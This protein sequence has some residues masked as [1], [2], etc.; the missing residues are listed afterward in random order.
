VRPRT[1]ICASVLALALSTP[2]LAQSAPPKPAAAGSENV[3]VTLV[4]IDA[5]VTDHDGTTVTGLTKDDFELKIDGVPV[6]VSNLD[7]ICPIGA[8]PDPVPLKDKQT[9]PPALIG[10]GLKRR[11]VF[12]FD[13]SFLDVT[14]RPQVLD[15]AAAM[16][17][18]AK[19]DD[20]EVMIVA[21]A[22][23]V[24][25]EQKFT[26][27]KNQLRQSLWR[28]KHD[29]TL[30]PRDFPVGSTGK[31]YFDGLT[32]LMDVLGAYDG[33]KAVVLF[34]E[35]TS[36]GAAIGD[37]M[38]DNVA[39]HANAS[40]ASFYPA[41]P[42]LLSSG[43]A[44]EV[45]TR[46]ANQSGGRMGFFSNDLSL[47]YRRAQR[48]LSCRYLISAPVDTTAG[49]DPEKLS[50]KVTKSGLSLHAPEMV[51]LFSEAER[52]AARA[53]AAYVDPGPYEHPLVRAFAYSAIPAGTNKWDTLLA[54]SFPAPVGPKGADVSVKAILRSS[55][56]YV[57]D[58]KRTIHVDPPADGAKSRQVTLMG[59]NKL[60][61]GQYD[62]TVVLNDATG[63]ELVTA[64]TDFVVPLV[65]PDLL[66]LRGPILGR[67]V[68][69]GLF[70]RANP[71]EQA[72]DTRVGKLIGADNG[73]E[74]LIIQE[75]DA[76]DTLLYYWSA[77]VSGA[78]PI[79]GDAVI[80]RTVVTAKGE[81]V[82]TLDPIP[83]KLEKRGKGVLCQ[84]MVEKL[85]PGTLTSGDYRLDVTVAYP[86]GDV[87]SNGT[88]PFTV[89]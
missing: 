58:Y 29:T 73:F 69:G 45:L 72:S 28:M 67:V 16:L 70:L 2:L 76:K 3:Q 56:A 77:C 64:Q 18:M 42:D 32:T 83:Y 62:M 66:M 59:N 5:V 6:K 14:M 25:I 4:Q 51:Q 10:P 88:S 38:F 57:D 34:S 8:T 23:G 80:S 47:P 89:R 7:L 82:K 22:G 33:S 87:I 41:K 60:S 24:R 1:S 78:D 17:S 30:W 86:N 85:A 35:A 74:P 12:A 50:V 13:Y 26:K 39:A 37:I 43:S 19:T 49:R 36:I 75:I 52:Q 40:N 27:D 81:P 11:V 63:N 31:G 9:T 65:I 79:K 48:D 68:P 20:E 54:V 44:G 53:Q 55:G 71:K 21:L 46:L 84:D 15:A 61:N